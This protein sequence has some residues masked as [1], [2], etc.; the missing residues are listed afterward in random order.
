MSFAPMERHPLPYTAYFFSHLLLLFLKSW[1]F[2]F[3][4]YYSE[5]LVSPFGDKNKKK[6]AFF[7]PQE[8]FS[9]LE[10]ILNK[11]LR[12]PSMTLIKE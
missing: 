6:K 8:V 10:R 7:C 12:L 1:I 3:R 9:H 2:Q 5:L 4:N 11:H